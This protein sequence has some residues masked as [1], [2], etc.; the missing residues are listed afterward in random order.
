MVSSQASGYVDQS[1]VGSFAERIDF[2][3]QHSEALDF[4]NSS[5]HR[6]VYAGP[7]VPEDRALSLSS[8][9]QLEPKTFRDT[10]WIRDTECEEPFGHQLIGIARP[11]FV[12]H[13]MALTLIVPSTRL[14]LVNVLPCDGRMVE[15]LGEKLEGKAIVVTCM[16]RH[17]AS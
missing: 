14:V 2:L 8:L 1:I 13:V 6:F 17:R 16:V 3:C 7:F 10:P 11:G 12:H 15:E 5:A 9:G 4:C